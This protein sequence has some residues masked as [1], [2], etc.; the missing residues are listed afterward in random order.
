MVTFNFSIAKPK[1]EH[2]KPGRKKG[3]K[4]TY[5]VKRNGA[6]QARFGHRAITTSSNKLKDTPVKQGYHLEDYKRICVYEHYYDDEKLPFYVG[7]GTIGR[8]FYLTGS[9]RCNEYNNKAVDINKI[10]VKIVAI[11]IDRKEAVNLERDLW[12]KYKRECE[13]GSLVNTIPGGRGGNNGQKYYSKQIERI[14][15]FGRIIETFNSIREAANKYSI[16]SSAISKN[17]LGKQKTVLGYRF[18]YKQDI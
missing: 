7:S 18:R 15:R 10:K 6:S 9:R 17:C 2:A 5:K 3:C 4:L 8:A 16:D 1:T 14:D 13:E 11:D 12:A